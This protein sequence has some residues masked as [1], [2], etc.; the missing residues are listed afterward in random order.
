MSFVV[1]L[2]GLLGFTTHSAHFREVRVAATMH[3]PV[4]MATTEQPRS[5]WPAMDD[6]MPIEEINVMADAV[7]AN[8][9]VN[10]DGAISDDELRGWLVGNFPYTDEL[11][12]KIFS[13]I[14]FDA[15]GEI[16]AMELRKA[17]VKY[18]T[19]R[20]APGLG[21]L[22]NT[23]VRSTWPA[24]DDGMPSA[25]IFRMADDIFAKLDANG[26]GAISEEE[27]RGWMVS[28]FEH[29]EELVSKIFA[30]IDFD[31]S[32]EID[33]EEL[34]K[35]MI[36]FPALRTVPGMGGSYSSTGSS[37]STSAREA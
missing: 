33:S 27:L 3:R 18:P 14:D 17:F 32:G 34:R 12:S 24:I 30:G 29:N 1:T 13:G 20:T 26:D 25:E 11:V 36:K 23:K 8:L 2:P 10:D 15:S 16:D 6:G 4:A 22:E 5:T 37:T 19:L 9:D 28:K 35:A 21:G 7:F 31:A